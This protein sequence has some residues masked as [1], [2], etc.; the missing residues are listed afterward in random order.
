MTYSHE[1]WITE[2]MCEALRKL[3]DVHTWDMDGRYAAAYAGIN[4]L[5]PRNPTSADLIHARTL[6]YNLH[7]KRTA[8][9]LD[10]A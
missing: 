3:Q 1:A 6:A 9:I 2:Q 4:A 7:Y 8:Y 10:V 5:D